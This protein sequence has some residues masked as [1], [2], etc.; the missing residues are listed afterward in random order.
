[1]YRMLNCVCTDT[2]YR[3]VFV[4]SKLSQCASLVFIFI[5]IELTLLRRGVLAPG[6]DYSYSCG[7]RLTCSPDRISP[8]SAPCF[9]SRINPKMVERHFIEKRSWHLQIWRRRIQTL[10]RWHGHPAALYFLRWESH[11]P[12]PRARQRHLSAKHGSQSDCGGWGRDSG[13]ARSMQNSILEVRWLSV[14]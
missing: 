13:S 11:I 12:Q 10:F 3:L 7:T 6:F 2:Q 4:V 5:L 9:N 1:M 8:E 14:C